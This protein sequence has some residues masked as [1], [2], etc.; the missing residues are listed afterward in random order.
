[1]H[2]KIKSSISGLDHETEQ[3]YN[4]PTGPLPEKVY[5]KILRD[6]VK[7]LY[8]SIK[9]KKYPFEADEKK[10]YIHISRIIDCLSL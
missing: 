9:D 2:N 1:M 8:A 6:Y 5:Q 3:V 10:V 4:N 7:N